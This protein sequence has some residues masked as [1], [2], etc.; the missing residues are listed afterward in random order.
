MTLVVASSAQNAPDTGSP[1]VPASGAETQF[2]TLYLAP[3]AWLLR[4]I[5]SVRTSLARLKRRRRHIERATVTDLQVTR[6]LKAED[7]ARDWIHDEALALLRSDSEFSDLDLATIPATAPGAHQ[8]PTP[9]TGRDLYLRLMAI[10]RLVSNPA[11]HARRLARRIARALR[12]SASRD[13][14]D[15]IDVAQRDGTLAPASRLRGPGAIPVEGAVSARAPPGLARVVQIMRLAGA[16]RARSRAQ[17]GSDL[18]AR[19]RAYQTPSGSCPEN[20][21]AIRRSVPAVVPAGV[22]A[23]SKKPN[24]AISA[25]LSTGCWVHRSMR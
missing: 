7:A 16:L 6:L 12:A 17:A 2:A 25:A 13:S 23:G 3:L 18:Q 24:S 10:G 22:C 20:S 1:A 4:T 9:R 14:L 19:P 15:P 8:P 21:S 11:F 5:L